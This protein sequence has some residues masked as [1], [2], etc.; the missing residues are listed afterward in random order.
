MP[1]D[2]SGVKGVIHHIAAPI[3]VALAALQRIER[4]EREHRDRH[5][6]AEKKRHREHR[7]HP[8]PGAHAR[9]QIVDDGGGLLVLDPRAQD[10]P[11]HRRD[12]Q[13][14]DDT[15]DQPIKLV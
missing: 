10:A 3:T 11:D 4:D 14:R 5:V 13:Q 15:A 9:V 6:A 8:P 2:W 12:D 7:H 1:A